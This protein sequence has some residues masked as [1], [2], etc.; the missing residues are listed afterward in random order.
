MK[1]TIHTDIKPE[2]REKLETFLTHR[3]WRSQ[4]EVTQMGHDY[5]RHM[6]SSFLEVPTGIADKE[7]SVFHYIFLRGQM[8]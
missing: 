4:V 6:K 1:R 8:N 3:F 5:G 2:G 7:N